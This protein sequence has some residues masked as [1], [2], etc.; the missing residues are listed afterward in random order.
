MVKKIILT[1]PA[2]E[3]GESLG[4]LPGDL[5]EKV[6]PYLRP[7]YDAL[8]DMLPLEKLNHFMANRVIEIAPL[9]FMR[10]R[11]LDNSFIILDE[12]QNATL[13]QIKMFLTRLGPSAKCIITGDLSQIDLPYHGHSG[14]QKAIKMLDHVE[15][16]GSIHLTSEDVVRHRLVKQIIKAF[17]KYEARRQAL[18][19]KKKGKK[20]EE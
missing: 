6:D 3:A 10:G 17:D 20:E 18:G 8:D 1:R 5:K 7:L 16:I 2:V 4:F 13:P 19:R 15:G 14:L 12:A 9:A 11:T